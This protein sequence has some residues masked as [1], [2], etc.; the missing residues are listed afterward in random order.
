[1]TRDSDMTTENGMK[2]DCLHGKFSAQVG[3]ARLQSGCEAHPENRADAYTADI[4]IKCDEC[5]EYFEFIGLPGGYSP[6]EPM[7]SFDKT[8]ARM[9][10]KP[11][12]GD[13]L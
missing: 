5:G 4:T 3:V 6:S 8:E 13:R 1:M 9:P 10:I 7:C 11:F 12:E 2:K